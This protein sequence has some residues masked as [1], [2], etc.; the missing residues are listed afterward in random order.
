MLFAG[1]ELGGINLIREVFR[2][3]F[4]SGFIIWFVSNRLEGVI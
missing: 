2:K 1:Q 3:K 4:S